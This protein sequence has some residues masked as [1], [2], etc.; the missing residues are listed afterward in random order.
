M[1]TKTAE[2]TMGVGRADY[3]ERKEARVDRLEARAAK[4]RGESESAS[5]SASKS[6][7]A[8][9]GIMNGQPILVGHH[10]EGRH[11]R[12]LDRMDRNMR[13]SI[14]SSREADRLASAAAAAESN[15]AV[16]SDDPDAVAKLRA[17]LAKMEAEREA[18]KAHNRKA[19]KEGTE[20]LPGYML[21]NLGANIRR[22]K[23]RVAEI[24]V[25]ADHVARE[26]TVGDFTVREN[27]ETNRVEI[28]LGRR[29][30][31]PEYRLLRGYGFKWSRTNEVWQRMA[32]ASAWHNGLYVTKRIAE[33]DAG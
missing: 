15:A 3:E 16:S 11:R 6:A 10:S 18:Y 1:T 19:R 13:K 28:D 29:A 14:D 33:G 17:K 21:S 8:M 4:A 2:T 30:S 20:K 23:Q 5:K 32:N 12:D 27:P 22:V 25:R 9:A 24:E 31:K 7:H 26:E